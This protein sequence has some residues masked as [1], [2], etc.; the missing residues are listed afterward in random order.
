MQTLAS[1]IV[2]ESAVVVVVAPEL[3]LAALVVVTATDDDEAA[4]AVLL[5]PS[6]VVEAVLLVEDATAVEVTAAVVDEIW[7]V[8]DEAAET[9]EE[10]LPESSPL[11]SA[12]QLSYSEV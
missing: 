6:D 4:D 3:V 9:A 1:V 10:L 5:A 7:N 8:D 11:A 12:A 2:D